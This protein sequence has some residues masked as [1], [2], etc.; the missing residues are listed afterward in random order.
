MARGAILRAGITNRIRASAHTLDVYYQPV[1]QVPV[2]PPMSGPPANL[3]SGRRVPDTLV[4]A[5]LATDRPPVLGVQCLWQDL[6][7][8]TNQRDRIAF[9][10]VGWVET[11][12]AYV[13][14]LAADVL[15]DPT[16]PYTA[17]VF[18]GM[19]YII[20]DGKRYTRAQA[21]PVSASFADPFSYQLW[22]RGAWK[23]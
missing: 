1:R 16:A 6:Q 23:D 22:L 8:I 2:S 13:R 10:E 21:D 7:R 14:V 20:H 12:H 18:D 11:A 4:P 3:L 17:T 5:A 9:E 15:L 19:A